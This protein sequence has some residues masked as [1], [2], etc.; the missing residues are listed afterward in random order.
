MALKSRLRA[1]TNRS[2]PPRSSSSTS[3]TDHKTSPNATFQPKPIVKTGTDLSNT[4]TSSNLTYASDNSSPTSYNTSPSSSPESSP[5]LT[6]TPSRLRQFL[7]GKR[8]SKKVNVC[9]DTDGWGDYTGPRSRFRK[10]PDP[11]HREMMEAWGWSF[12]V[13]ARC[14]SACS[15][16]TYGGISPGCSRMGSVSSQTSRRVSL[17]RSSQEEID[18][19]HCS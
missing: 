17:F 18:L 12:K 10:A 5:T 19:W 1:F 8:Q 14:G 6:K 3:D 15:N 13:D 11:A 16:Y 4:T 2:T 7:T 9:T